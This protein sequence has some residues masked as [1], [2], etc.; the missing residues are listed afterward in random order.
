MSTK[1]LVCTLLLSC[2]ALFGQNDSPPQDDRNAKSEPLDTSGSGRNA[3]GYKVR[4]DRSGV[5]L[6]AY[7]DQLLEAVREKW[8]STIP[9]FS[10]SPEKPRTVIDFVLREGGALDKMR[11]E[12]ASGDR[13]LDTAA[14]NAIQGTSPI[15]S[16]IPNFPGK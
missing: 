14:W 1:R 13:S 15:P 16:Q 8:Y 12:K 7:G 10:K 4:D 3:C 6:G 9:R 2:I 5:E 11:L